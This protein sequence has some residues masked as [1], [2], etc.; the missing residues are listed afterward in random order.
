M[1]Y[2]HEKEVEFTVIGKVMTN[3]PISKVNFENEVE[4]HIRE[5]VLHMETLLNK[6]MSNRWHLNIKA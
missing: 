2:K 6:G 3:A 4:E 5:V 1:S